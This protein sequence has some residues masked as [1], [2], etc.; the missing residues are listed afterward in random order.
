MNLLVSLKKLRIFK[1]AENVPV[2]YCVFNL[3][4]IEAQNML[5]S[6]GIIFIKPKIHTLLNVY[7]NKLTV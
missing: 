6:N 7:P 5:M 3:N 2:N 4:I 1:G